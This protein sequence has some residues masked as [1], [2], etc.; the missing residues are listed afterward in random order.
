MLSRKNKSALIPNIFGILFVSVLTIFG[1]GLSAHAQSDYYSSPEQLEQAQRDEYENQA[2]Q[3]EIELDSKVS[4]AEEQDKK[5][6]SDADQANTRLLIYVLLGAG[7]ITAI[8]LINHSLQK[9]AMEK[10]KTDHRKN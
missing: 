3:D 8:F 6:Q 5:E 10:R 4:A 2:T 9:Q 1:T 7:I